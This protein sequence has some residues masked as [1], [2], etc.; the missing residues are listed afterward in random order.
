MVRSERLKKQKLCAFVHSD[1]ILNRHLYQDGTIQ[2]E[3]KATGELSTTIIEP[4]TIPKYGT[5]VAPQ[6]N[7]QYHQHLFNMRIDP[8][9]DGI[10]NTVE[11]V[12]IVPVD[13]VSFHCIDSYYAILMLTLILIVF[14]IFF[15]EGR[16]K[17][18]R[19]R[20]Q[21]RLHPPQ[22]RAPSQ[23]HR[24]PT[25]RTILENRKQRIN[26]PILFNSG[27]IQTR[28]EWDSTVVCSGW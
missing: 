18:V 7:A 10:N 27:R 20:I 6:I 19:K 5:L 15:L 26:Q 23:T 25:R 22:N 16:F 9:I 4:N 12:D 11:E 17:P 21:T 13:M 14:F 24:K 2:Y 28:V 3:I 8:M 1:V